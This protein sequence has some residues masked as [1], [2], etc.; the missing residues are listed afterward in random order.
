MIIFRYLN[1]EILTTLGAVTSI[2][3]LIFLS[4]QLV[5]YLNWAA[6]GKFGIGMVLHLLL[7]EILQLLGIL[8]PLGLFLG[9]LLS[10][11]RL[12]VDHEMV[13]LNMSGLSRMRLMTMILPVTLLVV[14]ITAISSLWVGPSLLAYRENLLAQTGTALA[15]ESTLPGRFQEVNNGQQIFYVESLSLDRQRMQNIFMA[16]AGKAS[17][18]PAILPWI[19]LT[20]R[21]GYQTIDKKTGDRFFVATDGWRYQG[22]PGSKDFQMVHFGK[23]GVRI[24]KHVADITAQYDAMSTHALWHA[25]KNK[26]EAMA[27][28]QWRFAIPLSAFLL[29]LLAVPIS[30]VKPR[31]GK[32]AAFLPAILIYIIYANSLLLGRSW[33][34]QGSFPIHPGLWGIHGAFFL[35]IILIWLGQTGWRTLYENYR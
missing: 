12:Y 20:A 11:G 3:L 5:H 26:A 4:N 7:P 10:F 19:I 29:M 28:L 25:H 24:E 32:Y 18:N 8:L 33:M 17:E 30:R 16:Q 9:I 35:A 15:L 34:E 1:R 13:I 27:E 14:A 23:Y 31:Q 21:G 6:M 22:I 2:L